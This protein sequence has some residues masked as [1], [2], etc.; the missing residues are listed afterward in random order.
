MSA[1]Y[2]CWPGCAGYGRWGSG[3]PRTVSACANLSLSVL[4]EAQFDLFKLDRTTLRRL[5]TDPARMALVDALSQFAARIGSRLAATGV[6]SEAELAAVRQAGIRIAQGNLFAPARRQ[7]ALSTTALAVPATADHPRSAGFARAAE[8]RVEDF[9]QPASTLPDTA[10]C[11]DVRAALLAHDAPSG[12]VGLTPQ[13]RPQW[14]ADRGRFLSAFTGPFGYA[15]HAKKPASRL[16][17]PPRVIP[18]GAGAREMLEL[19]ADAAWDRCGDEVIVVDG[20]GRRLGVVLVAELVRGVADAK[21]EEA[22]MLNPLARLPGSDV[23]A[24]E[25]DRRIADGQA[26][27]VAWVDI[28]G[29]KKIND[30]AGFAAG[31]DLIRELGRV[32]SGLRAGLRDVTISNLGGDDFLLACGIGEIT[33]IADALLNTPWSADGLPA[34]LSLAT[35]ICE[36]SSTQSYRDA[37]RRLAPLKKHAKSIRGASWVNGWPGADR[38][39]VLHPRQG[40]HALPEPRPHVPCPALAG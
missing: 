20:S 2:R 31:D 21:I 3:W 18:V 6:E 14:M 33:T 22:T 26:H 25:V 15:L 27:V 30:T 40:R 39:E 10:T 19:F 12:V 28:D 4:A 13:L 11:E 17:D 32:L 24:R 38:A 34:T 37:S 7:I 5:P 23:V 35:L 36:K 8:L 16:A 29:F 9:L 1:T